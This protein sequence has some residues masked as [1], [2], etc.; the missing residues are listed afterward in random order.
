M[1]SM[2]KRRKNNFKKY[3]LFFI[4]L[5]IGFIFWENKRFQN[6]LNNIYLQ[7]KLTGE[8]IQKTNVRNI[9]FSITNG[10]YILYFIN[11][12]GI[13]KKIPNLEKIG[14]I[15]FST[16]ILIKKNKYGYID[17]NGEIIIPLEY[18]EATE[19][20]DG[21]AAVKKYKYGVINQNGSILLPFEYDQIYIGK[22]KKIILKKDGKYYTSNL[23]SAKEIDFDDLVELT[24]GQ[25]FFKKGDE[26]GVID[27]NGKILIKNTSLESQKFYYNIKTQ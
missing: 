20:K 14:E 16:P 6:R 27:I 23:K 5:I 12:N 17:R 4:L 11:Y 21:I 18:S 13:E 3:I 24:T 19:F 8:N 2:T 22:N 26:Y 25:L 1:V 7:K 10:K 15:S 9:F